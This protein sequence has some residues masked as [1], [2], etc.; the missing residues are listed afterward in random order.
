M[1]PST[2]P[3]SRR[4]RRY[5]ALFLT[6]ALAAVLTA[7][8][9]D[10]D[11]SADAPPAGGAAGGSDTDAEIDLS[12][13]TLRVGVQRDGVRAVLGQAGLLDAL[14][15]EIEWSEF[16]AGPPIV[17]AA[18]ADQIDVAWVGSTPPIFGAAADANFK[19]VAAVQERDF[20]ENSILVPAGSSI[21]SVEDLAG[22]RVA[23]GRGTSAQGLLLNALT[24]VGLT[25]DDIEPNYLSP[26]DGLAAFTSG[27]VDAWVVWDPFVTQAI[28]EEGAVEITGGQ[29]DERGVQFE[30]ASSRSLEDP[31]K[32]AAII[33]FVDRLR[34][35]FEWAIDNPEPWGIAWAEESGLPE[36]TTIVVAGNKAADVGPVTE[37]I[38][39]AQQQLADL[40]FEAG[41]LPVEVDFRSI[42]E[43]GIIE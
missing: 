26:A 20:Q 19:I 21:T 14:P 30:I 13:V 22:A 32:R 43:P 39:E 40:F 3:L 12:G 23:V 42:V 1:N 18:S 9:D 37:E 15:Y 7:C 8:G 24:R 41:E 4:I 2:R 33:D 28:Q 6:L 10:D 5:L 29:P 16:T 35:G 34:Q 31:A 25:L 17:E 36:S 11:A 38:I 27:A